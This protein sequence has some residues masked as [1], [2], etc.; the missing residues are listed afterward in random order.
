MIKYVEFAGLR[1]KGVHRHGRIILEDGRLRA[2]GIGKDNQAYLERLLNEKVRDLRPK[3]DQGWVGKDN[4]EI[5][6]R[7][8]PYYYSG[9]RLCAS[10][11]K[12]EE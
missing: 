8:F 5:F 6:L 1:D 3:K 4:P 12:V 7:I 10:R 9:G 11:V 2:E